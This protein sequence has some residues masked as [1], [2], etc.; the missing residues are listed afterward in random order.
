MLFIWTFIEG[1]LCKI[2]IKSFSV[3]GY[4]DA[5][6]HELLLAGSACPSG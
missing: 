5:P 4:I 2:D 6:Q 1:L 3:T